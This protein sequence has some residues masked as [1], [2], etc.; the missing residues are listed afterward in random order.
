MSRVRRALVLAVFGLFLL[1]L[2]LRP[3]TRLVSRAFTG[4]GFDPSGLLVAAPGVVVLLVMLAVAVVVLMRAGDDSEASVEDVLT[5][6]GQFEQP[7]GPDEGRPG[8]DGT[9]S[10]E[11]SEQ[12]P[13]ARDGGNRDQP[14]FLS[15][16]GGTRNKGFEIEEEPPE[17]ELDDHMQYL[18]EQL[19]ED[20]FDAEADEESQF[21][22][23]DVEELTVTEAAD[24]DER[25]AAVETGDSPVVNG[26]DTTVESGDEEAAKSPTDIPAECPQPYCDAE[27]EGGLFGGG[28]YELLDGGQVRCETCD[29]ITTLEP[30]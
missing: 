21:D 24:A 28:N 25:G 30:E 23:D 8:R 3:I 29:G 17:T 7:R 16:Q 9:E 20:A 1:T 18:Q 27:W 12:P 14:S 15:G 10:A 22:E 5:M 13:E 2:L 6:R 26:G 4:D 11:G 19:G